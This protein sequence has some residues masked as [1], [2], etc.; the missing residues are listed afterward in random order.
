MPASDREL[1]GEHHRTNLIP[2]VTDLEKVPPLGFSE[3]R[4]G[5]IT[6]N[7][8]VETTELIQQLGMAAIGAF[9]RKFAEQFDS[10][11]EQR[12]VAVAAGVLR[13]GGHLKSGQWRSPQNR[14]KERHSRQELL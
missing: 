1:A 14:P 11:E 13:L 10:F 4:H 3:R 12:G 2:H 5:P 9:R 6:D 7:Q 8:Q